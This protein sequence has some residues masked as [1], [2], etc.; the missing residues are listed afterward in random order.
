MKATIVGNTITSYI[1]GVAK[2][3]VT[4]STFVRQSWNGL[5][6]PGCERCER[7]LRVHQLRRDRWRRVCRRHVSSDEPAD[8]RFAGAFRPLALMD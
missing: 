7:Q 8:C 4:D 5:L 6:P 3:S 1:N 2:L